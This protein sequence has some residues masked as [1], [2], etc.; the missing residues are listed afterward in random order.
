MEFGYAILD[1]KLEKMG[2]Y[3]IEPPTL[4]KGRG[5]HP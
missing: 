3:M 4:F 2:N 5:D 1:N